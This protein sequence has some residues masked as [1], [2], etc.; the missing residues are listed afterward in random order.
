MGLLEIG[1]TG[2]WG[3]EFRAELELGRWG[4]ARCLW[5]FSRRNYS[6]FVLTH[7]QPDL[8]QVHESVNEPHDRLRWSPERRM[9]QGT[10]HL[11][12]WT[13]FSRRNLVRPV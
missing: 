7:V 3:W 1:Q 6:C 4:L 11:G 2:D 13:S 12:I 9:R 5:Y 10:G 8:W